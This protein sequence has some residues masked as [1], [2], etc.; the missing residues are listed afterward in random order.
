M[1]EYRRAYSELTKR[2]ADKVVASLR[3]RGWGYSRRKD[4]NGKYEIWIR[5]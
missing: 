1:A 2:E 4:P 3:K 5:R